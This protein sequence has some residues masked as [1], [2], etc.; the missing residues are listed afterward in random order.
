LTIS[1]IIT[2]PSTPQRFEEALISLKSDNTTAPSVE[3]IETQKMDEVIVETLVTPD[4]TQETSK[5]SSTKCEPGKKFSFQFQGSTAMSYVRPYCEHPGHVYIATSFRGTPN[6]LSYL[7]AIRVNSDSDK[8]VWGEYYTMVATVTLA[9]YDFNRTRVH[10]KVQSENIIVN[11][12][13]EFREGFE[14]LVSL[15]DDGDEIT[16]RGRF[17]DEGCGFTDCELIS[18]VQ[19]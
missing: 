8:I 14:E 3:E 2:D 5:E 18:S 4:Y 13:V 15:L 10:C 17:Y 11:F 9:D 7:E 1:G 12:S 16:F 19:E 6:D